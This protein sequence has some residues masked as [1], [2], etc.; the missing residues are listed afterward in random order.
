MSGVATAVVASNVVSGYLGGNAARDAAN[1]QAGAANNAANLQSQSTTA[2]LAQQKA[3]YDQNQANISPYMQTG[4]GATNTLAYLMGTG[5]NP[6]AAS[7]T[8]APGTVSGGG[9]FGGATIGTPITPGGVPMAGTNNTPGSTSIGDYGSLAHQF[10]TSDLATSLSPSYNF[11]LDQG[12]QALSAQQIA[13]GTYGSGQGLKDALAYNQN[14][15][16]TGYQQAYNNYTN[17][18]NMLY[19]KLSGMAGLGESAAVGAGNQGAQVGAAMANTAQAGTAA[20]N[21]YATG[22]AAAN[23]AGSVGTANA[24]SSA[25]SSGANNGLS[26]AYLNNMSP[27]DGGASGVNYNPASGPAFGPT[28]SAFGPTQ[29]PV[30]YQPLTPTVP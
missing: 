28:Q 16:S 18:Q 8:P 11:M 26:M 7:G 22:A 12:N 5:P 10:N 15:A 14:Y 4:S 20:A 6:N 24:W 27:S 3:M 1:T 17:N 2:Q 19:N 23:A 13:N 30:G 25:L 29:N 21:N 9:M